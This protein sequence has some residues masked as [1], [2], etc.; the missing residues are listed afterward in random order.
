M[1]QYGFPH[2]VATT[3]TTARFPLRCKEN[4]I[5]RPEHQFNQG[6]ITLCKTRSQ[7]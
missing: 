1:G 6:K 7:A 4:L 5:A 2:A 3:H